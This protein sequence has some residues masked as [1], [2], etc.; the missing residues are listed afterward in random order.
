MINHILTSQILITVIFFKFKKFIFVITNSKYSER[1]ETL[2]VRP[3][4]PCYAVVS[5]SGCVPFGTKIFLTPMF[6]LSHHANDPVRACPNHM[7]DKPDKNASRHL[8]RLDVGGAVYG[9]HPGSEHHYVC[10]DYHAVS[11]EYILFFLNN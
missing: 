8:I 7:M 4:I 1:L 9:I 2:F 3:Q 6:L 11:S 10:I 5:S